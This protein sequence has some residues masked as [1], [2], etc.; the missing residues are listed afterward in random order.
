MQQAAKLPGERRLDESA[1][2]T[3]CNPDGTWQTNPFRVTLAD[4]RSFDNDKVNATHAA[5]RVTAGRGTVTASL[6]NCGS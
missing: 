5:C 6:R 2:L 3:H 4:L 1:P